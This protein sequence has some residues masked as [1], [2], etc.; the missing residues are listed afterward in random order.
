MSFRSALEAWL[1]ADV[2][3]GLSAPSRLYPLIGSEA[4]AVETAI[5]K[6]Q[7][8]FSAGRAAAREALQVLGEDACEIPVGARRA[9]LWPRG[10]CGSITHSRSLCIAVVA[11]QSRFVSVGLDAEPYVPLKSELRRAI[12]HESEMEVSAER[13]IEL[14]G[15]KEALFKTLF[16]ITQE[17]MGFHAAKSVGESQLELTK[18]FGE[19]EEG[20]RFDVPTLLDEG[21]VVSF[22]SVAGIQNA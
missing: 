15:M 10:I 16:P 14:F 7:T 18:T 1:P 9:P 4:K 11:R 8:E 19:F 17:W 12:L 20:R 3:F 13:A 5:K 6:R 22:C 21:H 2:C